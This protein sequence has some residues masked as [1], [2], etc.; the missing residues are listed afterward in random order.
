LLHCVRNDKIDNASRN[1][2][3]QGLF[4]NPKPIFMKRLISYLLSPLSTN[5]DIAR[6]ERIFNILSLGMASLS[7]LLF[8]LH[9]INNLFTATRQ[10]GSTLVIASITILF[11]LLFALSKTGHHRFAEYGFLGL[12][13][14][15]AGYTLVMWGIDAPVG[16]LLLAFLIVLSGILIG[17]RFSIFFTAF[18]LLFLSITGL[19]QIYHYIK[20]NV[21]WKSQFLELGDIPTFAFTLGIMSVVSWLFNNEME[22]SLLRAR[23]AEKHLKQEKDGLEI[24]ITE[25]TRQLKEAQLEKITQVYRLAEFGRLAGGFFHDLIN[26]LTALSLNLEMANKNKGSDIGMETHLNQA[27]TASNRLND[28][29]VAIRGQLAGNNEAKT[30][31][32]LKEEIESSILIIDYKARKNNIKIT[33]LADDDIKTCGNPLKFNHVIVNMLSNA[34]DAYENMG[35]EKKRGVLIKM[36]N[37]A[38]FANILIHDWGCGIAETNIK[39]VFEMFFTTKAPSQ[40]LGIGLSSSKNIIENSFGGQIN[41]KSKED[42]AT[43]FHIQFP[44]KETALLS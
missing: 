39:K 27:I 31:F 19:L 23:E 18:C 10:G 13:F 36:Y 44:V 28:F 15:S 2:T 42:E 32:S 41:V 43:V 8:F 11:W 25:R 34:I 12:L 21:F 29:I 7:T 16:L 38:S 37:A 24:K 30:I 9:L 20:P 40:G 35:E 17:A 14:F 22:K 4:N 33:F 5:E 26:P 1:D 6:R 3:F